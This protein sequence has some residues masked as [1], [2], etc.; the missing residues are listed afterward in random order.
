[1]RKR[2]REEHYKM[3]CPDTD[4][5]ICHATLGNKT[6]TDCDNHGNG[7]DSV[8][9]ETNSDSMD[10]G[11]IL[12]QDNKGDWHI[13]VTESAEQATIHKLE[14]MSNL[15]LKMLETSVRQAQA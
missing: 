4:C 3:D 1:M 10:I 9:E 15:Q 11:D 7:D 5:W 14:R 12:V 6:D 2:L 8:D 13:V